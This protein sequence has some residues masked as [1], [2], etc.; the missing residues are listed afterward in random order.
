L[1]EPAK[2]RRSATRRSS[3][4]KTS[5]E[6]TNVGHYIIT[7]AGRQRGADSRA[8]TGDGES[9]QQVGTVHQCGVAFNNGDMWYL[10]VDHGGAKTDST[11]DGA[12]TIYI[13]G[14]RITSCPDS[15]PDYYFQFKT[16]KRTTSNTVIGR[17]VTLV[18]G[19]V[20][21]LWLP[22][23]FQNVHGGRTSGLLTTKV[24]HFRHCANSPTYHRDIE[25]LG[26]YW[27]MNDYMDAKSLDRLAERGRVDRTRSIPA[28]SRQ[29][30]L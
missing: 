5:G 6:V 16:A 23:I 3:T 30:R 11:K 17:D 2:V 10:H 27:A 9:G 19:D 29:L 26:Y 14:G 12:A 24:G 22:F 8:R 1:I 28:T 20:P 15:V 4:I 25:N 21:V 18:I 13:D 7:A